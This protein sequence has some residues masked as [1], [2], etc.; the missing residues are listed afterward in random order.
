MMDNEHVIYSF[1]IGARR[2]LNFALVSPYGKVSATL[3]PAHGTNGVLRPQIAELGDLR[4]DKTCL[5]SVELKF[6]KRNL[7]IRIEWH[8]LH[9]L[10]LQAFHR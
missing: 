3:R 7:A 5:V 10:L 1:H 2:N 9:T 4:R 6:Q 8:W